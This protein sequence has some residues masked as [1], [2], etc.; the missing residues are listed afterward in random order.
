MK[1]VCFTTLSPHWLTY[2]L[3]WSHLSKIWALCVSWIIFRQ[4][5]YAISIALWTVFYWLVLTILNH[6]SCTQVH[7]SQQS[8]FVE[9]PHGTL[10]SWFPMYYPNLSSWK[11]EYFVCHG[12]LMTIFSSFVIFFK[13]PFKCSLLKYSVDLFPEYSWKIFDFLNT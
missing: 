2:L 6:T 12:S 1:T 10:F 9:N 5:H 7:D 13:I 8:H 4:L 3:H 11:C